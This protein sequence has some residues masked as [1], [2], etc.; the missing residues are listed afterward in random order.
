[1]ARR[2][3]RAARTLDVPRGTAPAAPRAARG[4]QNR[5]AAPPAR[6]RCGPRGPRS[7]LARV[8][9]APQAAPRAW[10]GKRAACPGIPAIRPRSVT[11]PN[12][13]HADRTGAGEAEPGL[14]HGVVGLTGRA[15]HPV[16]HRPQVAP[17][18][19][20]P[21]NEPFAFFHRSR[22]PVALRHCS[23]DERNHT[24]V[25][26]R[27]RMARIEGVSVKEAGLKMRVAYY[28]TQRELVGLTER[29]PERIIEP[30]E[31]YA[32]APGL[33]FAYGKIEEAAGKQDRVDG[34]LKVLAGLMAATLTNCEFCIDLGSQV[35]RLSS[36]SDEQIL[37]LSDYRESDLFTDLEKL[38][39]DY[40]T[41]MSRTPVEVPDVLFARLWEHFDEAQLVELTSAIALENIRGRFNLALGVDAAGFSAG[42]V[43]A[44]PA[45][46]RS[47][48]E[49]PQQHNF[50]TV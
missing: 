25:T 24:D 34:R 8:H 6:G 42:L 18:R 44:V 46:R 12:F 49:T 27:S 43:C 40:A 39:L 22:S 36:L 45:L 23:D 26:R 48:P 13:L 14:L 16:G 7:A 35:A 30:L 15:E 19:L 2:T 21:V 10:T 47:M 1:M 11:R 33:M 38:V 31:L 50:D 32:H 4:R 41:G 9:P 17:V 20:E 37:A 28:F 5:P 29:E 3:C